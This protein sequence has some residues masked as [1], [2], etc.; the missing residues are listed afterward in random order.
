MV[1]NQIMLTILHILIAW[2]E[3]LKWHWKLVAKEH[4]QHHYNELEQ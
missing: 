3:A 2:K 1:G 4:F